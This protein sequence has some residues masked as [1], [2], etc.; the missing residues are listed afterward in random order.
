MWRAFDDAGP[1]QKDAAEAVRKNVYVDDYLGSARN[2]QEAI[3][4]AS[5]VNT[6][7]A[8]G[9]F[10]LDDWASNDPVVVAAMQP[11]KEGIDGRDLTTR[12]IGESELE[13]LLG[14]TWRPSTDLMGF[15]VKERQVTFSRTRLASVVAGL[16]DPL[17]VAATMT[18]KGKIQLRELCLRG[19]PWHEAVN[20][21]DVK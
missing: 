12:D 15:K 9:D 6:V 18:V 21:E 14:I 4:A 3:S 13:I 19:L 11:M 2:Q 1:T 8:G 5:T 17:G 16:F 10:H 20:D 7:L